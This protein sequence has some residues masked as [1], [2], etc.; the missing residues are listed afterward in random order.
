M[1]GGAAV[2]NLKKLL[3]FKKN[4]FRFIPFSST[5]ILHP[6]SQNKTQFN[7]DLEKNTQ[8]KEKKKI[9]NLDLDSAMPGFCWLCWCVSL[10]GWILT[11]ERLNS[12]LCVLLVP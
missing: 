7:L 6:K 3:F 10:G 1:G 2:E 5:Q 8:R 9:I 12:C 11:L 4:L